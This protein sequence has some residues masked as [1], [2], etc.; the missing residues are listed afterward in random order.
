VSQLFGGQL[1]T[2]VLDETPALGLAGRASIS[3]GSVPARA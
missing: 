1:S 2:S 3:C